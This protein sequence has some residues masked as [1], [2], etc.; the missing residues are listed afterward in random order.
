MADQSGSNSFRPRFESALQTYQQMT[1]VTLA[2]HTLA[3]QLLN[4]PSAES[5]MTIL[6]Y[7]VGE[8]SDP[9][10]NDRIMKAIESTVSI[11]F[12][13]STTASFGDTIGLVRKEELIVCLH[14]PDV[15]FTVVSA[16]E[17][18]SCW[19]RSPFCRMCHSRVPL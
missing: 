9:L 6:Q 14:I 4:S 15:N 2:E 5:V 13:L 18:N 1:G 3:A 7:E 11:L 16:C 8:S 19:P 17:G 10:R 12:T